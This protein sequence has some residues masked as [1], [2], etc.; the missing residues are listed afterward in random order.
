M[1]PMGTGRD[2]I[3]LSKWPLL[4]LSLLWAMRC[5]FTRILVS[6]DTVDSPRKEMML[7]KGELIF[8]CISLFTFPWCHWTYLYKFKMG[9]MKDFKQ[10]IGPGAQGSPELASMQPHR[11]YTR[12]QPWVQKC[13]WWKVDFWLLL[14]YACSQFLSPEDRMGLAFTQTLS[15]SEGEC[16]C[17]GINTQRPICT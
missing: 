11:F 12:H 5:E 6:W 16:K 2:C 15:Y 9:I 3:C 4:T 13:L 10:S 8:V 7:V 17:R 1:E 14:P